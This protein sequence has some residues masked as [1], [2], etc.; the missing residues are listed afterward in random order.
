[1]APHHHP[2]GR[3]ATMPLLLLLLL[4]LLFLAASSSTASAALDV[5]QVGVPIS[6]S[7]PD[8]DDGA[9]DSTDSAANA[10]ASNPLARA[11]VTLCALDWAAYRADPSAAPMFRDVV[12]LSHCSTGKHAK[13]VV[14]FAALE[15]EYQKRACGDAALSPPPPS[16]AGTPA[17]FQGAGCV[18]TGLVL[19][20]SRCGSTLV[21]NMLASLPSA[22]IYSEAA[23]PQTILTHA[24]LSERDRVRALRVVV[25]AMGRPV[26]LHT[27][28]R[29]VPHANGVAFHAG[30]DPDHPL[31]P[32]PWQPEHMFFKLQSATT[33]HLATL[34]RAFPSTPWAFVHRDGTEVLASL[35]RGAVPREAAADADGGVG[36]GGGL[37]P[38][39]QAV[40]EAPC[41]RSRDSEQGPS[42]A[43]MAATGASTREEAAALPP[44]AYCAASVGLLAASALH[45]A[46]E[47]RRAGLTRAGLLPVSGGAAGGVGGH[48]S[49]NDASSTADF[50]VGDGEAVARLAASSSSAS[51][52]ALGGML[53][54]VS[55]G[56]GVIAGVGQGVF[57]DYSALPDAAVALAR[58]H[59]GLGDAFVSDE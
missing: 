40:L 56:R 12:A 57:V 13:T 44:E 9:A 23:P 36:V 21:A 59:F 14:S 38:H 5:A 17:G 41:M 2:R 48:G 25:A 28:G 20:Q 42:E 34:R 19:H 3:P 54:D 1:M 7:I 47:A 53:L 26:R 58:S 49:N 55:A 18:P 27:M 46:L 24:R 31:S 32:P 16:A 8:E 29:E 11:T 22:L 10:D 39:D 6:I 45:H 51:V 43:L 4:P 30:E 33:M 35:L 52:V 15:D 50:D 37:D